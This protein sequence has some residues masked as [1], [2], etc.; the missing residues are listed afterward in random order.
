MDN[1]SIALKDL[2]SRE[3]N[4]NPTSSLNDVK[5]ALITLSPGFSTDEIFLDL[6]PIIYSIVICERAIAPNQ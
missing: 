1:I 2:V 6:M 4:K 3:I 5:Q